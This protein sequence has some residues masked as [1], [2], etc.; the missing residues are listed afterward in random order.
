[1]TISLTCIFRILVVRT[2]IAYTFLQACFGRKLVPA[3]VVSI[4]MRFGLGGGETFADRRFASVWDILAG[5]SGARIKGREEELGIW[6][7]QYT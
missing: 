4:I 2:I 5:K 3:R 7:M 1:L 6:R